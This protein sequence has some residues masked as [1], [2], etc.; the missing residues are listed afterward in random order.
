[1]R[2]SASPQYGQ[3]WGKA[4]KAYLSGQFGEIDKVDPRD[5]S[6]LYALDRL[7]AKDKIERWLEQGRNIIF[8]RYIESNY[9]HQASKYKGEQRE[10]MLKWLHDLEIEQHGM[11]ES[12]IVLYLDLPV[13]YTLKAIKGRNIANNEQKKKDIHEDNEKH[14]LDTQE[15]YRML[16]ERNENWFNVPCLKADN[17]RY[18]REELSANIWYLVRPHLKK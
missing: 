16:V 15:T 10:E 13:E 11:P 4:I 9:A 8:D 12:D 14:L 7:T 17:T 18:S 2:R 6:M 3:F 1:M 5:A